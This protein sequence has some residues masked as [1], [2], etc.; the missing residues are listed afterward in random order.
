MI[1]CSSIF[2]V[3]LFLMPNLAQEVLQKRECIPKIS[4]QHWKLIFIPCDEDELE[5]L[6]EVFQSGC[7]SYKRQKGD[8][9]PCN[10]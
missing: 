1:F 5:R 4:G 2:D 9:C 7:L 10:A 6:A 8:S 3:H